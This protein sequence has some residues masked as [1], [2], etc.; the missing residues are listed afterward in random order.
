MRISSKLIISFTIICIIA[1]ANSSLSAAVTSLL[2]TN[3]KLPDFLEKYLESICQGNSTKL[4]E[5]RNIWLNQIAIKQER[6]CNTDGAVL[7]PNTEALSKNSVHDSGTPSDSYLSNML[8]TEPFG[9]GSITDPH[10]VEGYRDYYYTRLLAPY[11]ASGASVVGE[12]SLHSTGD[13]YVPAKLGPTGAQHVGDYL[14][15]MGCNYPSAPLQEW[16]YGFIGYV[17]ISCPNSEF[18]APY[19][20]V[21]YTSNVYKYITAGTVIM[22][23]SS[24]NSYSDILVDAVWANTGYRQ[25]IVQSENTGYT[26]IYGTQYYNPGDTVEVTATPS[27][28]NYEFDHWLLDQQVVTDNPISVTMDGDH[29]IEA[30]F[31]CVGTPYYWVTIEGFSDYFGQAY[32]CV[33]VDGQNVGTAPVSVYLSQGYHSITWS[34]PYSY[35]YNWYITS[36]DDGYSNGDY[37]PIFSDSCIIAYYDQIG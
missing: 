1:L 31:R 11:N 34:D 36:I 2:D 13:F 17:Q 37:R 14:I 12:M 16:V 24:T 3:P 33:S 4:N 10:N 6:V 20:Y 27:N 29:S 9:G 26:S 21:G 30:C 5:V 7:S 15:L 32:P 19:V 22:N 25:L 8:W 18:D 23:I 35:G 28:E